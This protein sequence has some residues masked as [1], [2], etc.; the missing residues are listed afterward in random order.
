MGNYG[1]RSGKLLTSRLKSD[2]QYIVGT[3][4]IRKEDLNTTYVSGTAATAR[5]FTYGKAQGVPIYAFHPSILQQVSFRTIAPLS[6]KDKTKCNM[7][8]YWTSSLSGTVVAGDVV[9]DANYWSRSILMSGSEASGYMWNISGIVSQKG[10]TTTTSPYNQTASLVSGVLQ[11]AELEIPA[12]D[13][14][15]GD[16][17]NVMIYRDSEEAADTFGCE[18]GLIGLIVEYV[19]A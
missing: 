4:F 5:D 1:F 16:I 9:W 7:R 10:N 13:V 3:E 8:L 12:G 18:A 6:L 17:L 15:A 11:T 14:L 19:E 2:G